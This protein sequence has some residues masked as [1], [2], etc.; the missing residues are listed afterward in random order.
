MSAATVIY[1]AVVVIPIPRIIAEIAVKHN[2][3]NKTPPDK[4]ITDCVNFRPRPETKTE[5]MI[6]PAQAHAIVTGTVDLMPLSN[7]P[8]MSTTD[9]LVFFLIKLR[10]ITD[11]ILQ[12]PAVIAVLP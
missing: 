2:K 5:P 3:M 1:T 8:N 7:A 10:M 9:I 12:N 4:S 11:T 6:I